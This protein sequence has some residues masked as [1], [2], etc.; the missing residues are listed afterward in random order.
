MAEHPALAEVRRIAMA[1]PEV[2]E[3][4]SHGSPAFF[5][6][7]RTTVVTFHDDHHGDGRVAIWCPAPSGVQ[8]TLV[9]TEPERF[10]RPPY[11]GH[12][13]WIGL[14]VDT[15]LDVEELAA[16]IRDAYRHVAPRALAA[17]IETEEAP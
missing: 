16:V 6:R 1:L 8:E 10:F 12:R 14:R 5:V 15:D 17:R 13:G 7:T 11:V 2:T 4:L 9:A 3:R